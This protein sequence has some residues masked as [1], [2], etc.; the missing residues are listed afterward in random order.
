MIYFYRKTV[1]VWM[2]ACI[3]GCIAIN[4]QPSLKEQKVKVEKWDRK[5]K[6]MQSQYSINRLSLGR[7]TTQVSNDDLEQWRAFI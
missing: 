1:I 5:L 7:K 3:F 4:A 6:V 2:L